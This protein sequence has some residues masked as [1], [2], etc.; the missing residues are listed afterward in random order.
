MAKPLV[1]LRA[2]HI[3]PLVVDGRDMPIHCSPLSKSFSTNSARVWTLLGVGI[4]M[5]LQ[6]RRRF[7][8][9]AA[10]LAN[11][12]VLTSMKKLMTLAVRSPHKF[13]LTE[14]TW[15]GPL[16]SVSA[17]VLLQFGMDVEPFT[18]LRTEDVLYFL[19]RCATGVP[20]SCKLDRRG[21]RLT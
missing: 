20:V 17:H 3:L 14:G 8:A 7:K 4:N 6:I 15:E 2:L 5:V 16:P 13:L 11:K 10:R 1:A 18:T 9:F 21:T 19:E 12:R